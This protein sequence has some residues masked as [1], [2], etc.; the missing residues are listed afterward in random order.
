MLLLEDA[1]LALENALLA[2]ADALLA[3]EDALL[4]LADALLALADALLALADVL[5]A[6]A[7]AVCL[8]LAAPIWQLNKSR[9]RRFVLGRSS[10]RRALRCKVHCHERCTLYPR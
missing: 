7:D 2:L 4:A 1:L 3:R 9:R 10:A 8:G 5:L 6:L